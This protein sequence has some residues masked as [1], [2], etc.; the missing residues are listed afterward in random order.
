VTD[1]ALKGDIHRQMTD[2]MKA[3]DKVRVGALRMFTSA[4]Q[5]KEVEVGHELSDEEIA[6]VATKEV[7]KRTESIAAFDGAGRSELADKE[8][9]ERDVIAAFAP[10]MLSEEEVDALVR[11]GIAATGASSA[12]EFG[13]VMGYV[14]GRAKGGVDGSVV[15]EKVRALLADD[16]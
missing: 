13:K 9:Q 14:M 10:P 2:A 16:G 3:G 8:R 11:E 15:Q 1:S 6:E 7:K 4:I 12:K 5:Y